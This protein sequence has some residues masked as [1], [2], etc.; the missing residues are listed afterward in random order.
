MA[1]YQ[2]SGAALTI[3]TALLPPTDEPQLVQAGFKFLIGLKNF[4]A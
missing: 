4:D 3:P 1:S 2:P